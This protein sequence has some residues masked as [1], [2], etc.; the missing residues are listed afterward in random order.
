MN[1]QQADNQAI[2]TDDVE[3]HRLSVHL[4]D[5]KMMLRQIEDVEAPKKSDKAGLLEDD[6]E[7]HVRYQVQPPRDADGEG[8]HGLSVQPPRDADNSGTQF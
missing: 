2:E 1:E 4:D 6:V 8:Q 7:G 5:E 3:A